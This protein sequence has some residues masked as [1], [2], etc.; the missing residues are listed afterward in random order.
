MNTRSATCS[1]SAVIIIVII[2]FLEAQNS[3][4][5]DQGAVHISKIKIIRRKSADY[6]R[7]VTE[8]S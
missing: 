1:V 6:L 5:A 7:N 4:N 3:S 8:V 2:M